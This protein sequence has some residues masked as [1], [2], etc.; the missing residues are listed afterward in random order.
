MPTRG[1]GDIEFELVHAVAVTPEQGG[2]LVSVEL[3]EA[4]WRMKVRTATMDMTRL[5]EWRA[6]LASLKGAG[7]TF[8]GLDVSR[9]YPVTY[10]T[11]FAGLNRAGGGSFDGTATSWSVNSTRDEITLNGLPAS[12]RLRPG[13][14]VGLSWSSGAKRTLHRVLE[15]VTGNGSGVGTWQVEPGVP[16]WAPGGATATLDQPSAVMRVQP[17]SVSIGV[18]MMR[19]GAVS[20][21]AIQHLE[22]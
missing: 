2:R 6:F 9:R 8:L 17:G 14:M 10:S 16:T 5:G 13:D 20:F 3:G 1:F 7:R 18:S 11:G 4:R 22:A 12:F 15:D 19:S 21:D